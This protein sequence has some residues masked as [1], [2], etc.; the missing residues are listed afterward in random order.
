ME[1]LMNGRETLQRNE[2][3]TDQVEGHYVQWRH[4]ITPQTLRKEYTY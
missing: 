4:P 2:I 3:Q 1:Q